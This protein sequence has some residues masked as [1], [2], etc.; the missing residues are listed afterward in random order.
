MLEKIISSCKYVMNN[1]T[2]VKINYSKLDSFIETINCKEFKYWLSSN[3]Y[4]I[5]DLG[6]ENVVNFMLI[7]ESID[8]SFWGTP[9][10]TIDTELGKK[11][12]TDALLY[13]LLKYIREKS[14]EDL[15]NITYE[16]FRRILKGN[17]EIP[18]LKER[19]ETL[20][21]INNVLNEKMNGNFYKYIYSIHNDIELFEIIINNFSSFKDEREFK[22]QTIYF[23][24]LAQLLTSDI[25]HIRKQLENIEVDYSHLC[26]CADYKIPQTMR[27]LGIIEYNDELSD[28]IDNKVEIDYSSKYE[29]EIRASMIVVIDYIRSKIPNIN[30]IDINDY[31]FLQSKN[32]KSIVKPYHLCRN[33]NY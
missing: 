32:V 8:Y 33:K 31:F 12:G 18:L 17:I 22:G 24:K 21:Q 4:N 5:L 2:F 9:K 3:P 30:A 16:D 7:F 25:L 29:V 10:W 11:D 20:S 13:S 26:G 14:I 15:K 19:H 28:I 23:Y 1:A 6:I 27:A